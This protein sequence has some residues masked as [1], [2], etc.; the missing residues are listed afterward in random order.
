MEEEEKAWKV[1]PLRFPAELNTVDEA[2]NSI[3]ATQ[4]EEFLVKLPERWRD[5]LEA[6]VVDGETFEEIGAR[7]GV[8]RQTTFRNMQDAVKRLLETPQFS[9]LREFL[10]R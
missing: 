10:E 5:V 8:T 7:F 4:L 2:E 9:P 1:I 6:H 3:L